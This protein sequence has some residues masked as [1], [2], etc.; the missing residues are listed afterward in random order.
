MKALRYRS[1]L[2]V[3]SRQL[4]ILFTLCVYQLLKP[5]ASGAHTGDWLSRLLRQRACE[6]LSYSHSRCRFAM[7]KTAMMSVPGPSTPWKWFSLPHFVVELIVF[8]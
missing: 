7:I 2:V 1:L 5:A 8:D 6:G 3:V 4:V